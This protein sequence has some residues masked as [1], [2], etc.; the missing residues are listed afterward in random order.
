MWA[1]F[2]FHKKENEAPKTA[3]KKK[4]K[5]KQR[6]NKKDDDLIILDKNLFKPQGKKKKRTDDEEVPQGKEAEEATSANDDKRKNAQLQVAKKEFRAFVQSNDVKPEKYVSTLKKFFGQN[7]MMSSLWAELKR[8]RQGADMTIQQ[9]WTELCEGPAPAKTKNNI[10]WSMMTESPG[11][12]QSRL[13]EHVASI[14]ESKKIEKKT[15]PIPFDEL[16]VKMGLEGAQTACDKGMYKKW[17]NEFGIDMITKVSQEMTESVEVSKQQ[18]KTRSV[19]YT[20]AIIYYMRV[21]RYDVM[22]RN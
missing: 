11:K 9:A 19:Q 10:L 6:Q 12:W 20:H 13:M 7:Q 8:Q 22:I 21:Y 1:A 3:A 4:A 17:T 16:A 5:A 15:K 14:K 18:T 2:V